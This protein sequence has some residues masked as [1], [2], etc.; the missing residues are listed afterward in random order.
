MGNALIMMYC[1]SV[2]K[3]WSVYEAMGFRNLVSWNFM[4][5]GFQVYGCENRAL[6]LFSQ[7]HFGGI[8]PHWSAFFLARVEWVMVLNVDFNCSVLL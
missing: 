5:A 1:R 8:M 6:E 7:M 2:Y 3:A 4:I